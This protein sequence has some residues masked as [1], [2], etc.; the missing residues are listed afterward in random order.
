MKVKAIPYFRPQVFV[1]SH[2]LARVSSRSIS[3]LL[4]LN[5]WELCIKLWTI[6][7]VLWMHDLRDFLAVGPHCSAK[8]STWMVEEFWTLITH[9][10]SPFKTLRLE[11][12]D[13]RSRKNAEKPDDHVHEIWLSDNCIGKTKHNQDESIALSRLWDAR[14][15]TS[16]KKLKKLTSCK[17]KIFKNFLCRLDEFV[18]L[19]SVRNNKVL[20]APHE[21]WRDKQAAL[22][23]IF[24]IVFLWRIKFVLFKI[25]IIHL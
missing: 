17:S 12:R 22:K 1:N 10:L 16:G 3:P 23:V 9:F 7:W 8:P 25:F 11:F 5:N 13:S 4:K 18:S 20:R 6:F 19:R 21:R 2:L 14:L 24:T 15:T